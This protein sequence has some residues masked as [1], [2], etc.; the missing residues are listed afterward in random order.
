MKIAIENGWV[1]IVNGDGSVQTMTL[2]QYERHA[3][4][5]D[6]AKDAPAAERAAVALALAAA[7][8]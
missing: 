6:F 8:K 1:V 3:R 4:D 7:K 2:D 5:A